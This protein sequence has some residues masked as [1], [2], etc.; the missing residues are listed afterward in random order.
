MWSGLY[1]NH[2]EILQVDLMCF[3]LPLWQLWWWPSHQV[4]TRLLSWLPTSTPVLNIK[5]FQLRFLLYSLY[6]LSIIDTVTY[7]N[8]ARNIILQFPPTRTYNISTNNIGSVLAYYLTMLFIY[9]PNRQTVMC[10]LF[11]NGY[12]TQ[13]PFR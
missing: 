6:T 10:S 1:L 8:H 5:S 7:A 9:T 13:T 3:S 11:P 4:F 2:I 12:L